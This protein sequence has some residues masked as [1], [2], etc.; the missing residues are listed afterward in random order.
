VRHGGGAGLAGAGRLFGDD[1]AQATS[2]RRASEERSFT[3]LVLQQGG[4]SPP[5]GASFSQAK[6]RRRT[7]A[8]R[9][10]GL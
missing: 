4:E 1:D 7:Q 6:Q 2:D 10:G 3:V 5:T 8:R 9:V